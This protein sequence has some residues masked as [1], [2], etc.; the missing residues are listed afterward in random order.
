M[1][2]ELLTPMEEATQAMH[3]WAVAEAENGGI[4]PISHELLGAARDIAD[5]L[6]TRAEAVLIRKDVELLADELV[7]RGADGVCVVQ[8]MLAELRAQR[9]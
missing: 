6:A 2:D 4:A 1:W 9:T 3:A 8:A 5:L 7:S